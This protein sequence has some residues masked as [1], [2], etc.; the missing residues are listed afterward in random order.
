MPRRD[1]AL[2]SQRLFLRE[3]LCSH[4]AWGI[5]PPAKDINQMRT[6]F[7]SAAAATLLLSL[8]SFNAHAFPAASSPS[9][10]TGPD[11]ILV[12]GGCGFGEHRD[13]FGICRRNLG[14]PAVVGR[15]AVVIEP[16]LPVPGVVVVEPRACPIGMHWFGRWGRCIPNR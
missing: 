13:R 11:V 15:P 7:S 10:Y 8:A 6:T 3:I 12:E 1:E 14:A 4:P 5:R 16:A 9:G 2:A